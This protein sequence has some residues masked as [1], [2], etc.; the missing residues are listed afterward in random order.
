MITNKIDYKVYSNK[1]FAI[2]ANS[3]IINERL[4]ANSYNRDYLDFAKAKNTFNFKKVSDIAKVTAMIGWKGLTTDD[5][6][7]EDGVYLLRTVD[8]KDNYIDLENAVMA[9]REKVYEQPQIILKQGDIIFSKDG[10]LGITAI[11]PR[12]QNKEMCVGST[13]AR[14]RLNSNLDNYYVCAA[15]MSK[16]VQAQIGYFTSGIAQPHITQEYINKLEIP[17]PSPEIQKYIGDKVR[18]A[19]ELREEAKR[20]K[21]EAEEILNRE[22]NLNK[23]E[24]SLKSSINSKHNWITS[25]DINDRIDSYY[26][27]RRYILVNQHLNDYECIQIRDIASVDYGY[28]PTEDYADENNGVPLIRV[29]NM[30]GNLLLD[31]SDLKYISKSINIPDDKYVD[32]GD[33]LVVQ[34]GNTTG[35]IALMTK[36]VENYLYPSFCLRIKLRNKS[37]NN[38]YLALLMEMSI[39]QEQIWQSASYSSVRPNTTKPAIENIR[40]PLIEKQKQEDVGA[41]VEKYID[42]I[43][44]S[45][46]LILEAKQDVEDLIEGNFDMSKVKANS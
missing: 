9:K 13:L 10:T 15:F 44:Q 16:I 12:H 19:E 27:K 26:Y 30:I 38:K 37:I 14:I 20:L 6:V 3:R 8:I 31:L 42:N 24:E 23:L 33:I 46:Q 32:D 17:I 11:V 35:K 2:W 40:I 29:T 39:I 25:M 22:L 18:K 41:L 43:Y 7:D 4:S 5:Y 21:K 36:E 34:C 28:M 45:K 1:P